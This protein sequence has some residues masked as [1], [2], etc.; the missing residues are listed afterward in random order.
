MSQHII[1][2]QTP[3]AGSVEIIAGFDPR[4]CE[5]FVNYRG[6]DCSFVSGPGFA[7]EDIPNACLD[8]LQA[9]RPSQ[10]LNGVRGDIA[11]FRLGAS[12]V[13]RRMFRYES[14]GTCIDEKRW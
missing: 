4:L 14:D 6:E 11:D 9:E 12:D 8:D 2:L 13:G 10:V 1:T 3:T 5:V 7:V